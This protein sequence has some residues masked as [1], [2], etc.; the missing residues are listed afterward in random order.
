MTTPA[1]GADVVAAA[2][3]SSQQQPAVSKQSSS[4]SSWAKKLEFK[5]SGLSENSSKESIQTLAKW[6]GFNRKH[7]RAFVEVLNRRLQEMSTSNNA[8]GII[9]V[10]LSVIH[11][12]LLLHGSSNNSDN[13][14][15]TSTNT[16]NTPAGNTNASW[17]KL[18]D[19]RVLLGELVLIPN[20]PQIGSIL[21]KS[22][23]EK[24]M[25][26]TKEWDSLNAFGGPTL[27]HQWKRELAA[28]VA[29]A[30]EKA[31]SPPQQRQQQVEQRETEKSTTTSDESR[32]QGNE[33]KDKKKDEVEA[34]DTVQDDKKDQSSVAT[35]HDFTKDTPQQGSVESLTMTRKAE[36][37]K[38][39]GTE[40][41]ATNLMEVE[42]SQNEAESMLL[43]SNDDHDEQHEELEHNEVQTEAASSPSKGTPSKEDGSTTETTD[44]KSSTK[45]STLQ[46]DHGGTLPVDSP[47]SGAI[48]I[49]TTASTTTAGVKASKKSQQQSLAPQQQSTPASAAASYDFESKGIP[50]APV[51]MKELQDPCRSL[52]TFQIARDLRNDSAQQ[53]ASLLAELPES[54]RQFTSKLAQDK[55]PKTPTTT[56][57]WPVS[58]MTR[59][60]TGP[61]KPVTWRWI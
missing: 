21:K 24:V 34:K 35:P 15:N 37:T 30:E 29:A 27:L 41:T 45:K 23:S 49:T 1:G 7:G 3:A 31:Q 42:E 14:N 19:L 13:N 5:L 39:G 6:I 12:V 46:L 33:L 38:G 59:L 8:K 44:D 50:Q 43:P 18:L 36:D 56:R 40:S 25:S 55:D 16:N 47:V 20:A 32:P 48:A 17:D 58:P 52:A 61:F 57:S 51:K 4:L 26:Y 28:G 2:E 11:Q 53:L 10:T 9:E 22:D 60:E 54:V